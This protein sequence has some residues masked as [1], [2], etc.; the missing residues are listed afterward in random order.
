MIGLGVCLALVFL[1]VGLRMAGGV[2][3]YLQERHNHLSFNQNEYRILCLGESTTA[4]GGED[5]YPSQLEQM[6]NLKSPEKKFT[7]INEG[8]ISTTTNTILANL[9]QN[10]ARYKP[11][12]VVLMMGINDKAYLQGVIKNL[13]WEHVKSF[14]KDFRVYKLMHLIYEHTTHRIKEFHGP[15]DDPGVSLSLD[16]DYHQ[17][18]NSLKALILE[19]MGRTHQHMDQRAQYQRNGQLSLAG[20][21]EKSAQQ[22]AVEASVFC[23]ELAKRYRIQGS[24]QGAQDIL[25]QAAIF[26]PK[27]AGIYQEWGE[28]YL[29]EGKIDQALK[30][31]QL[32]LSLD[33]QNSDALLGLAHAYH[34]E[35]DDKAFIFYARYLQIN[36]DYWG[37]IE[38]AQWLRENKHL[39]AALEYLGRAIA[40]GPS[41]DEAYVDLGQVLD[42]QGDYSKE[43]AFYLKETSLR[44]QSPRLYQAL[45]Q[46]YQKQG[47]Q[48]LAQ[49]YFQKAAA[50]EMAEYLPVTLVNF[51]LISNTILN[52]HIKLLVM[53]YPLRNIAP[54][55]DYLGQRKG[56]VFVE[57]KQNFKEALAREGYNHYFKDNFAFDFGHCTREGNGLI[58]R[59]LARVILKNE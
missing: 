57:N 20:Q 1:E 4:L 25:K 24:F 31:F 51:N 56:L 29:L 10:L 32:A 35:H 17:V 59:N 50:C 18:E 48:D 7:V 44:S 34:Q 19:C 38:L 6:L 47:R 33:P 3:L 45:G 37:H 12:M 54:L 58:A 53:Q 2:V 28:M 5:S 22:S 49:G 30:A 13:W 27:F 42:D 26:N 39:D 21:E 11:Q 14:F 40:I 43:E 55:K 8:I 46:F 16:G 52:R 9:D 15:K 41:F 23:V 36:P